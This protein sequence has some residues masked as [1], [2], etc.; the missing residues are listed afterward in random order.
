MLN[1]VTPPA[2]Q[3]T[4]LLGIRYMVL[5]SANKDTEA[6]KHSHLGNRY[7]R[8]GDYFDAYGAYEAAV[9]NYLGT[10][11]EESDGHHF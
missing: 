2:G 10:V 6:M 5:F 9:E 8:R 3:G 1:R 4:N 11:D 7:P